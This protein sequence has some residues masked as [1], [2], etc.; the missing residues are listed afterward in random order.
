MSLAAPGHPR[1]MPKRAELVGRVR[2]TASAAFGHDALLPGQAEAT[3]ALLDGHDVLL[4]APTGSGK[5]L[6]YQ[7]AGL[8]IDGP[9]VVVS[10]LLALQQDQI[11]H[12]TQSDAGGR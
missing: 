7:V 3:A 11:D 5:S 12:I 4:V 6:V 9:T 10:P 8:V 2:S 1:R